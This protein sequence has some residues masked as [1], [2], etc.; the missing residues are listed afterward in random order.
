VATDVERSEQGR[1]HKV[2][3]RISF[4]LLCIGVLAGC[5]QPDRTPPTVI[6]VSLD[7]FRWDY[8]DR[9]AAPTLQA[10]AREGVRA[11]GLI[12]IFPSKTFPNHYSI[13]TG[14]YPEHHGLVANSMYDPSEDSW[15]SLGDREAVGDSQW[16][17]GE[18]VWVTAERA[19]QTTA[20]LFWPGAEAE[21][22]GYRPTY[23][24]P[25]DFED[26]PDHL[27]EELLGMLDLPPGKRPTFLTLYLHE[28]DDFGHDFGTES[29]ELDS[30]IA[31]VDRAL[32]TLIAGLA[33]RG[34]R[35]EVDLIVVSDHGMAD[36]SRDR[37]IYLDDLI[38]LDRV[39]VS[40]WSPVVAIWPDS[41]AEASTY[42]RLQGHPHLT[43]H[44][45]DSIPQR[46]HYSAHQRIAPLIGIADEGWSIS[47]HSYVAD[48]PDAFI[49]ATHGY[50]PA[51]RSMLGL[52][53]ASGPS[54]R[55][56]FRSDPVANIHLYELMCAILG[57][58]PAPNDG[59]LESVQHL[60]VPDFTPPIQ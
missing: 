58:T 20:P 55:V 15:Y 53:V 49:G 2:P 3:L 33:T 32:A 30:A 44:R 11:D 13:V 7:G 21:I 42:R 6:L 14:L 24:R 19:G 9:S 22:G 40:D 1:L 31:L 60:L 39:T 26:R 29:P 34:L 48:R 17:G 12:S 36:T 47:T 10:I 38:D 59:S 5:T 28:T 23:W 18:P 41:G 25:F 4:F 51:V 52:F 45:R 50:D 16:Y 37:I 57:L 54:F 56:G 8:I 35:H 46:L 27:V 43:V